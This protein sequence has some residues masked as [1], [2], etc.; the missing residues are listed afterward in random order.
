MFLKRHL[1]SFS[2]AFTT[3]SVP[4]SFGSRWFWPGLHARVCHTWPWRALSLRENQLC[5]KIPPELAKL[6]ENGQL[7]DLYLSQ[8]QLGD[9]AA[10]YM[11]RMFLEFVLC[12][13]EVLA[14]IKGMSRIWFVHSLCC[15]QAEHDTCRV[16]TN[17]DLVKLW[18]VCTQVIL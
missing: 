1:Q 6:G 9:F 17:L 11:P 7:H 10:K 5:G 13:L 16:R 8:N 12:Y 15:F 18:F 3:F 14:P 4:C 2:K